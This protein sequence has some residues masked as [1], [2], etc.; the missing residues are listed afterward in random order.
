[1]P[2]VRHADPPIEPA[3]IAAA[4]NQAAAQAHV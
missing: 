4:A 2:H 1:M 3:I